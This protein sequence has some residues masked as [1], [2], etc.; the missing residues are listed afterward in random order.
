MLAYRVIPYSPSAAAGEPGHP[1]YERRPQQGGRIDHPDYHVWYLGRRP[2]VAVGETFGNLASW[3][4]SMFEVPFLPG[5]RRALAV[6]RLPDELRIL[7]RTFERMGVGAA[8]SVLVGDSRFDQACAEA[9]GLDFLAV[10]WSDDTVTGRRLT[11]FADLPALAAGA[12][13]GS[14]P[15]HGAP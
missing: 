3:D 15:S 6:L 7:D 11:S 12:P 5:G 4:A 2:E 1:L 8:G 14:T 9:A 13:G 10:P